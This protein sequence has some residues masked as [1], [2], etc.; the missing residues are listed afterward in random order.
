MK[1]VVLYNIMI[2]CPSDV[3]TAK[4]I[5]YKVVYEW[6][7]I[8]SNNKR[9]VLNPF[10]WSNAYPKMGASP[11]DNINKQIVEKTDFLVAVFRFRIGTPTKG[12]LSGTDEE[13][14]RCRK[15]GKDVAVYVYNG[16]V[17]Q[18]I[19][20]TP[21]KREQYDKLQDYVNNNL[22]RRGLY[23]KYKSNIDFERKL[24]EYITRMMNDI[25]ETHDSIKE[26]INTKSEPIQV[27]NK[28]SINIDNLIY[29]K[30]FIINSYLDNVLYLDI[31]DNLVPENIDKWEKPVCYDGFVSA[32][33]CILSLI[34]IIQNETKERI[35]LK[36]ET[37]H[38]TSSL[39][40]IML[41]GAHNKKQSL[42]AS[43]N[44]DII[45][46]DVKLKNDWVV[47]FEDLPKKMQIKLDEYCPISQPKCFYIAWNH[48]CNLFFKIISS[49]NE[50]ERNEY[51]SL[52][53]IRYAVLDSLDNILNKYLEKFYNKDF[54]FWV[55][56]VYLFI[57]SKLKLKGYKDIEKSL[58]FINQNELAN[59]R[60]TWQ[61]LSKRKLSFNDRDEKNIRYLINIFNFT[62][63]GKKIAAN[64]LFVEKY[65]VR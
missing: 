53:G 6:N 38:Y 28:F 26:N 9:I 40:L 32:A 62:E 59:G 54:V 21:E 47:S 58:D 13:I 12:Y 22:A 29:L 37:E 50:N 56:L 45:L 30:T 16:N 61:E 19:K 43:D 17:P 57:Q 24:R 23:T 18:D 60:D 65:E 31:L 48:F 15:A 39:L 20:S 4:K 63:R 7:S 49:F 52:S 5:F 34:D 51:F 3:T 1:N 8:N 11:Q 35:A 36:I 14:E 2:S 42:S 27:N 41:L 55:N 25:K 33:L 10:D 64:F 44:I 46:N